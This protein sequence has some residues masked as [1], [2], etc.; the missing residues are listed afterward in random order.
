MGAGELLVALHKIHA[1]NEEENDL[2]L[3]SE[4]SFM[5]YSVL[6]LR[7]DNHFTLWPLQ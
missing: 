1:E 6:S 3:H 2:L 5:L 7:C 4:F